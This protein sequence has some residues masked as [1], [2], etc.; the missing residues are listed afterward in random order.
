[1]GTRVML[2]A[3]EGPGRFRHVSLKQLEEFIERAKGAALA[4]G[5]AD[6]VYE[7]WK[8][9]RNVAL[10]DSQLYVDTPWNDK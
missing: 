10:Q 9:N 7:I 8:S 1:M 6:E 2:K 3:P 5:V 4:D